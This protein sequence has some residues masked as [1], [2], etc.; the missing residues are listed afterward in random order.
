M[1]RRN[2]LTIALLYV[3]WAVLRISALTANV[4]IRDDWVHRPE[5]HL[6]SYRPLLA[7]DLWFWQHIIG[8][9][10]LRTIAPKLLGGAYVALIAF[11]IFRIAMRCGATYR[12][13]L[14][15]AISYVAHPI[16]NEL[17]L[18]NVMAAT[19]LALLLVIAADFVDPRIG[20]ILIALGISG[21]QVYAFIPLVL[22]AF[23]RSRNVRARLAAWAT[24]CA[25]YA[26][27]VVFSNRVLHVASWGGR[28]M[29]TSMFTRAW[30][31][32][33]WHGV[34]N[35]IADVS[36]PI[37]GFTISAPVA[38]RAW[39]WIPVLLAIAVFVRNRREA[40]LPIALPLIACAYLFALNVTPTGWR[41]DAPPLFALTLAIIPLFAK[42]N[43]I[44]FA[45]LVIWILA[46]SV[47]SIADARLRVAGKNLDEQILRDLDSLHLPH[48]VIIANVT[49]QH[50]PPRGR[51][52]LAEY[53]AVT[54]AMY[55]NLVPLWSFP[56]AYLRAHGYTVE[57]MRPSA[58]CTDACPYRVTSENG[59]LVLCRA[60]R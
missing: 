15:I 31:I 6:T 17:T 46:A 13:A 36:Q 2:A 11:V 14:A 30:L 59:V 23:D 58:A 22:I 34:T 12:S 1:N 53:N 9:D 32:E 5:G 16:N 10:Y 55:S 56:D 45:L 42:P 50:E 37:V 40:F 41:V 7:A 44:A 27:Y 52:I 19:N 20:A 21:Y 48:R 25:L 54:P 24:G 49:P 29:A 35:A 4:A 38:F 43:R 18:F 8:D 47:T 28:G 60:A 3:V 57:S 51:A 26:A 39:M 33:K